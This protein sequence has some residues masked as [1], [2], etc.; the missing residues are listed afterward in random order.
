MFTCLSVPICPRYLGFESVPMVTYAVMGHEGERGGLS[1]A[2]ETDSTGGDGD[3]S[4]SAVQE[5]V[6]MNSVSI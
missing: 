3:T 6:S 2:H 1:G 5:Y 4:R